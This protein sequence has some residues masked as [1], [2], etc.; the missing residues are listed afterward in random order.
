MDDGGCPDKAGDRDA[1]ILFRRM[2]CGC[3]RPVPFVMSGRVILR[4]ARASGTMPQKGQK[5]DQHAFQYRNPRESVILV[6]EMRQ[7]ADLQGI[8]V[9]VR[10]KIAQKK[11]FVWTVTL[12]S[13]CHGRAYSL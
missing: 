8:G 12:L 5:H 9:L 1:V 3:E 10:R 6:C 11:A 4:Q 2:K 7:S 13:Q